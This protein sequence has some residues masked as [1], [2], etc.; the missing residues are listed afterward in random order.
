MKRKLIVALVGV[1]V[2]ASLT[3]CQ[4][5]KENKTESAGN[6]IIETL[7][8][9][10]TSNADSSEVENESTVESDIEQTDVT[11]STFDVKAEMEKTE[12]ES[13]TLLEQLD[14]DASQTQMNLTMGD[15]FEL[16]DN[17]LN[18]IWNKLTEV[19]SDKNK[20]NLITGQREWVKRKEATAKE[21][22]EMALGGTLQPYL[23]DLDSM[24]MTK[25]RTYYLACCLAEALGDGY[26]VPSDVEEE[27]EYVDPTLD[28]VF[29][30]FEGEHIFDEERGACV[31][32]KKSDE[33]D[34]GVE[35]SSYTF[36]ISGGD[37]LSDLD[38]SEYTCYSI[39]FKTTHE[40]SDYYY[41]V[42]TNME[43]GVSVKCGENL[44][45]PESVIDCM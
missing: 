31:G 7:A 4:S 5:Q 14:E 27:L 29:E 15:C 41:K 17:E 40:G 24:L 37:V 10:E 12:A 28:K 19:V 18:I 35:N 8:D 44:E 3:G 25:K 6:D 22:G 42:Y 36:W 20:D 34:Y 13:D 30:S 32:I 43:N 45:N 33:C 9:E 16:W 1:M 23:E 38:V 21:A 2:F 26:E 11:V 39:T